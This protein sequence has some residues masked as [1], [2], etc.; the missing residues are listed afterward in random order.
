M[1]I[2]LHMVIICKIDEGEGEG[3]ERRLIDLRLALPQVKM[4]RVSI[5]VPTCTPDASEG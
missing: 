4:I 2:W 1:V 5:Y 3:G